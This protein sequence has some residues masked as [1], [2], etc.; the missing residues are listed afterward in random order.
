MI[1]LLLPPA[2]IDPNKLEILFA[3]HPPMLDV[4]HLISFSLHHS[5]F[6]WLDHP[7]H[8]AQNAIRFELPHPILELAAPSMMFCQP[9]II[10]L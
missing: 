1:V 2:I 7:I 6:E 9:R 3:Y 10:V 8:P 4:D 5:I